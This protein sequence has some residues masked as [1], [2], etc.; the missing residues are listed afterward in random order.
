MR[1]YL[2]FTTLLLIAMF[3]VIG[4][5]KNDDKKDD[6]QTEETELLSLGETGTLE[7]NIGTFEVTPTAIT[8]K[9][10]IDGEVPE[11]EGHNFIIIDVE[12]K[13]I[14]EK[15]LEVDAIAESSSIVLLS[16]EGYRG[17]VRIFK[18]H[19]LDNPITEDLEPG[20]EVEGQMLFERKTSE[21][22]DFRYGHN[23]LSSLSNQVTWRL[24]PE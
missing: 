18:T 9:D 10:E 15:T 13:N 4:C 20:E 17:S 8:L 22:Y 21:Y 7:Q 5:S 2:K 14:G 6:E 11:N 24:Y 19:L 23:L 1:F 12:I 3:I 16:D